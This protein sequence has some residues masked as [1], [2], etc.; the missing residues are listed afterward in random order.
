MAL[1]I[2]MTACKAPTD[3]DTDR[4]ITPLNAIKVKPDSTSF[5]FF[6]NESL[7]HFLINKSLAYID[8]TTQPNALWLDI[9]LENTRYDLL[10]EIPRI[11]AEEI[12][13]KF[14]SLL[15]DNQNFQMSTAIEN[16]LPAEIYVKLRRDTR[17]VFDTTISIGFD[18]NDAMIN[19]DYDKKNQSITTT[20]ESMI[21]V[22]RAWYEYRDTVIKNPDGFNI[23][24]E[25]KEYKEESD[26]LNLR[27][28]LVL[29][30]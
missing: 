26:S 5:E 3:I 13:I 8:T 17:K 24:Y 14:D 27:G 18:N 16:Q 25:L 6:E 12:S 29:F 20:F 4:D 22:N 15:I 1:V 30:Y 2:I 10:D 23:K 9:T 11:C 28:K 21:R 7:S 19:I